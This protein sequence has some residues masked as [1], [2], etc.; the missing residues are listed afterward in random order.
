MLRRFSILLALALPLAAQPYDLLLQGGHLIDPRNQIDEP[1]D[2]AIAGGKI[3]AV[4]K[5]IASSQAK[6]VVDAGGMFVTPG[7]I[8]IHAHVFTGTGEKGS[9]AGDTSVYP[10]D[11]CIRAGV[12]TAVDAGGAGADN[13]E[14]FKDLIIDRA[15]T[16]VLSFINIVNKGMRGG[17]IEQ[18]IADMKVGPTIAMAK[19]HPDLIVGVKAAHFE[20][21]EWV[22]VDNAVKAAEGFGG[23]VMVDFGDF[24][25]ERPFEQL[26]LERLRPGDMY[27]HA[28]LGRVPWFDANGKVNSFF[29]EARVRGV[30]FDVGHGGG[31]LWWSRVIP[32]TRQGFWPDSISTDL[33]TQSMKEGMKDMVNV[34]SKFL[35]L[36]APLRDVIRWSTDNPAQQIHRPD[37]GHL[38]VGAGAD[39]TVLSRQL[40]DFGFIDTRG[41]RM[42]GTQ[43]LQCELTIRDGKVLWDLNGI[44]A[45]DW[46]TYYK[47]M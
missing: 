43:K 5:S 27:T 23:V 20:G 37:L 10:D 46:Q 30:K 42:D 19:K 6:Q 28:Y 11:H 4:E 24:R 9:L 33:H 35:N 38:S 12:T 32:A 47:K 3:A 22:S 2:V 34:M 18:D 45:P 17:A 40:G 29:Y 26:V 31:S 1:M 16:R 36:G 15:R 44:A 14:Q 25:K 39:I 7:L 41:A 21:P 8:D 13:F